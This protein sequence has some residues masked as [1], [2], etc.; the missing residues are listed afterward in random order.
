M[1]G[2]GEARDRELVEVRVDRDRAGR[3]GARDGE[4]AAALELRP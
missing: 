1:A 2:D 4:Q 3:Q